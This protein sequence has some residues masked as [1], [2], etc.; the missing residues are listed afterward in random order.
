MSNKKRTDE[1]YKLSTCQ[2]NTEVR[3]YGQGM[4]ESQTAG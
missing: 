4:L 1:T 2:L 3:E